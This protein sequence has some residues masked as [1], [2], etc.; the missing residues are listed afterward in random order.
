M[1]WDKENEAWANLFV[2]SKKLDFDWTSIMYAS[3]SGQCGK[4]NITKSGGV[5]TFSGVGNSGSDYHRCTATTTIRFNF[6]KYKNLKIVF[7]KIT[8]PDS[9]YYGQSEFE[10]ALCYDYSSS[11]S[12]VSPT[13]RLD[14]IEQHGISIINKECNFDIS[15]I[16]GEYKVYVYGGTY[17]GS[18]IQIQ[19]SEII[20][21]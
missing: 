20:V 14:H 6:T 18:G 21:S 5:V 9:S 8:I 15:E 11:G 10:I 7:P 2:K 17:P 16:S 12:A 13:V 4:F 3:H 19:L 1:V